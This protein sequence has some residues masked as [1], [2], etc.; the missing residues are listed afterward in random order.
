MHWFLVQQT[1]SLYLSNVSDQ[2]P[3]TNLWSRSLRRTSE[4]TD[5]WLCHQIS[6]Y[7]RS[8]SRRES[9]YFRGF[10]NRWTHS[11]PDDWGEGMCNLHI[12]LRIWRKGK[13]T[14]VCAH[15]P[16][17]LPERLAG[18]KCHLPFVQDTCVSTKMK[19]IETCKHSLVD[20]SKC[21]KL[22]VK[23]ANSANAM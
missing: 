15:V 11:M 20:A 21:F 5:V 12:R 17:R 13:A 3:R 18:K 14:P 6:K 22:Y 2:R 9:H 23:T 8:R 16:W 10:A 4:A 7:D 19:W 1:S